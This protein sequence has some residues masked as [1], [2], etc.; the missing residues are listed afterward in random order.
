M[1]P[2]SRPIFRFGEFE[3]DIAG[4]ALRRGGRQIRL[5]RRPMDLLILLVERR[6]ELVSRA[7]IVERLWGGGVFV[8]ADMGVNTAIRKI[9]QVLADAPEAPAFIE[10]VSGKGYRFIAEVD[11]IQPAAA[12]PV[13]Q[14]ITLAVLPFENLGGTPEQEYLADGF[15]EEAT[16]ALGQIDPEHLSVIGRTSV[17]TYK[18][19]TK[20]LAE[21]GRELGATH[22]LE[23]SVR[24]EQKRWRVSARLIRAADQV[25]IWSASFDSEPSSMLE[26]QRELSEAI[27]ELIRLRLSPERLVALERRQ[28]KSP[29]AYDLYLRGRHLWNQLT[30]P[31]NRGAVEHFSRAT[32]LDPE[33]SLAWSGLADA[34]AASPMNADAP[35]LDVWPRA[36]EA[37]AHA[38][39]SGPTIAE[40]QTSD[41]MVRYWL[42]WDWPGS[43]AA[44]KKAI[45]LDPNYAFAHRMLGVLLSTAGRHA[46]ARAAL[47]R[48]RQLDPLQPMNHA[49]SAHVALLARDHEAGLEFARHAT[50][51][52]PAFWI[53]Y[54]QLAWAYERLGQPGAALDALKEAD[55]STVGNSKMISL[56]GYI[57][58]TSGR[59]AEAEQVLRVLEE[60]AH[61]RYVPPY[62]L[63]LVHAG[64]GQRE[65]ALERLE[66]AYTVRDVHLIWL[67]TDPKWDPFRAEPAFVR[68]IERS[69]FTRSASPP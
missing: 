23:G 24:G 69:G 39:A 3:L 10:T 58:A 63:A 32:E 55:A 16:T 48:A 56:R 27:A 25:Q 2:D 34:Y 33:Y 19:T 51:V 65:E 67:P 60:I 20:S 26:F 31:T 28:S 53:A 13:I 7:D 18:R 1:P 6:R 29:D 5:E 37:A 59:R 54:Y 15:T 52:G 40:S 64:L 44:Y 30:R 41:G 8:D 36:R 21:I 50:I 68:L 57:L 62:A 46:E 47:R 66:Q 4:Y 12:I 35:P 61:E 45:A 17:L 11:A 14:P 49:L 43:E 22:L 42:D 38:V 9:R